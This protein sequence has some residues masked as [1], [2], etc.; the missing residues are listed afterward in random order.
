MPM[1]IRKPIS[2]LTP[3]GR[4]VM[5]SAESADRRQRQAEQDDE[6]GDQGVEREHHRHVH[7]QDRHRHREVQ[8]AERLVHLLG[9]AGEGDR[10]AGRDGPVR[11]QASMTSWTSRLTLPVL[12]DAISARWM[13]PATGRCG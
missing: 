3:S 4:P 6:R 1:S 12:V 8:A 10:D 5:N 2:A 7:D 11:D 9:D 13:P